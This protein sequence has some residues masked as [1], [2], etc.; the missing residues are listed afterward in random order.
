MSREKQRFYYNQEFLSSADARSIRIL[1]EYYGP[2]QRF[3][4]NRVEDTIVFFGSARIKDPESAREALEGAAPD[5]PPEERERLEHDLAMSRYYQEAHDLAYRLTEWSKG[6]KNSHHRY[7]ITSGG[8]PG[9]MEAANRGASDAKGLAVGLN[10]TLPFEQSGNPWT[11][12]DLDMQFHYFFMRKFWMAYLA[13]ALIAFPGGFGTLDELLEI[14]TLL[15]TGKIKKNIPIILYGREYW[16]NVINW[17]Y[18]VR[19]KTIKPED[20]NL[21]SIV[22]SVDEAFDLIT[23]RLT[24]TDFK[25]PNF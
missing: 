14:L 16:S 6:L 24:A 1:A 4:R 23:T 8:G 21:F 5:L 2:R 20:L 15:Q 25:G 17:K 22:D 3:S 9:V 10:I 11:T 7:I 19:V 13:K 12:P 18:L